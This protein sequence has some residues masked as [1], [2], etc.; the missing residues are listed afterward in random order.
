MQ[1]SNEVSK[2]RDRVMPYLSGRGVDIGGYDCKVMPD[3]F[4]I[5][6][7]QADGVDFVTND[8]YDVVNSVVAID[9]WDLWDLD[10]VFS[11]HTLEHL[12]DDYA[13][14]TEWSRFLKVG[15]YL[16]LYLP[17]GRRYSNVENKWHMRDY[18]YDNF[19]LFFK[20]CFCGEGLLTGTE[21]TPM[22]ELVESGEDPH[23]ED[24]YSFY[25][26]ARKL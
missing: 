2:I 23:E 26:V 6:G 5:D 13:A 16:I 21:N 25:L 8:L 14:I 17:D 4:C 24:M 15:G 22:F 18:N 19:M 11:S 20:R 1:Y 7:R 10:Y 3:A 9:G 12:K